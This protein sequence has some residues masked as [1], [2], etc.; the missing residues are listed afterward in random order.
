MTVGE[1]VHVGG[2]EDM[3]SCYA[4]QFCREPKTALKNKSLG[5]P[6]VAQQ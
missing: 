4:S 3:G 6:V 2:R 1:A 5:V